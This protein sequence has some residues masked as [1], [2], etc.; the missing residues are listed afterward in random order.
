MKWRVQLGSARR[1]S[2]KSSATRPVRLLTSVSSGIEYGEPRRCCVPPKCAFWM[3]PSPAASRPSSTLPVYSARCAEPAQR[4][5]GTNP[6]AEIRNCVCG[7][8]LF[9]ERVDHNSQLIASQ[10]TPQYQKFLVPT[11]PKM[12]TQ[13][14]STGDT[15]SQFSEDCVQ[16][17]R[18]RY[19]LFFIARFTGC[20]VKGVPK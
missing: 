18:C 11:S 7:P 19:N 12:N 15:S 16:K 14:S 20:V 1:I 4:N 6:C 17:P 8:E 10:A 13:I 9:D 2:R 3:L 5:T